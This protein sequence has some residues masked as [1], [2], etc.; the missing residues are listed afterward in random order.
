MLE[1]YFCNNQISLYHAN[2]D[3][4]E[5]IAEYFTWVEGILSIYRG[6]D[7]GRIYPQFHNDLHAA[8]EFYT[9]TG[10]DLMELKQI[11]LEMVQKV[12]DE[13]PV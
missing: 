6:K 12:Y 9:N 8:L 5:T 1:R 3:T 10:V 13:S 2:G 7:I 11:N 4:A